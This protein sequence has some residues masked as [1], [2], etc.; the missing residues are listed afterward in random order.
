MVLSAWL[1]LA[2]ETT[3]LQTLIKP[4]AVRTKIRQ[5]AMVSVIRKQK[6]LKNNGIEFLPYVTYKDKMT[7]MYK[8]N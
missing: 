7:L 8:S 3:C 2:I 4:Q 5:C 1:M 6:Q